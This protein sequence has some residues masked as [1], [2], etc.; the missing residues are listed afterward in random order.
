[1][2]R[3]FFR[4]EGGQVYHC[5]RVAKKSGGNFTTFTL[6]VNQGKDKLTDEWKPA[7]FL[8]VTVYGDLGNSMPVYEDK[9]TV[10][11][12]GYMVWDESNPQYKGWKHIATEVDVQ[13]AS[14]KKTDDP[15]F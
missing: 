9:T 3:T 1:M 10:N 14:Q 15:P 8:N 12:S 4:V 2:A 13:S 5:K 7:G 6:R 11:V